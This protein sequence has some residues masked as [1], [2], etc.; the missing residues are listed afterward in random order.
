MRRLTLMLVGTMS[1]MSA[2][3]FAL[4]CSSDPAVIPPGDDDDG[5]D[6]VSSSGKPGS[7]GSSGTTSGGT[8]SSGGSSGGSSGSAAC[9]Q[10]ALRPSDKGPYCP[11]IVR[12]DDPTKKGVNCEAGQ[13]C[14]NG[15]GTGTQGQFDDSV[16][17]ASPEACPTPT[18]PDPQ[19]QQVH[20]YQCLENNDCGGGTPT[21][22]AGADG[23]GT[24][25]GQICCYVK[26]PGGDDLTEFTNS[27][28]CHAIK[29]E[30]GTRCRSACEAGELQACQK[31]EDCGTGKTCK[32]A[33][34]GPGGS[35]Y[36][37]VCGN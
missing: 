32:I 36:G 30:F 13:T 14:C 26:F 19:A 8:T 16:C 23:G 4:A 33:V 6:D 11:F 28:T 3:V 37:G 12:A 34:S 17:A 15:R 5:D 25:G 9:F 29:G 22:D 20:A 10:T 35:I 2:G 27:N 21:G 1:M 18:N 7:S 24:G 31:N